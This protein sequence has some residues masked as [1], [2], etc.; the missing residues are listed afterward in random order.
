MPGQGVWSFHLKAVGAREG[1]VSKE[2]RVKSGSVPPCMGV[3]GW[4]QV[5][6]SGRKSA[7][8]GYQFGCV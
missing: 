2:C 5:L 8:R 3:S 7:R 4:L 1:V 6:G